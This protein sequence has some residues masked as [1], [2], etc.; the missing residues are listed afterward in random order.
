LVEQFVVVEP[1]KLFMELL[2]ADSEV[3][4]TG[5]LDKAGYLNSKDCWLPLGQTEGNWSIVGNQQSL[6][7]TALADKIVNS[8][9]AVLIAEC[10][11][12]GVNPDSPSAPKTMEE[13]VEKFF[14]IQGGKL[15][16]ATPDQRK[17]VSD[18]IFLVASGA[19]PEGEK[20]KNPC[21]TLLDL[22]EGQP[23]SRMTKTLLSLPTQGKPNK[24]KI[25]FVQGL[26]NMG[27]TGVLPFCGT[28]NY[29]LILSKRCPYA[30]A[31]SPDSTKWS[32][33]IIRRLR[34]SED[35]R[36]SVYQYLAPGGELLTIPDATLPILP[37]EYPN[38][39]SESM[40]YGTCIKLYEYG[41]KP[42]GLRG[43]AILDLNY[44][45]SR[46][47]YS[48]A[49]PIRICERRSGYAAH[50]KDATLAGMSVRLED[51]R[52]NVL[53]S[54]NLETGGQMH[55]SGLGDL[56]VK[57]YGFKRDIGRGEA[58]K[59]WMSDKGILFALNGQTH[60]FYRQDFFSR[61][62]VDLG[63]L[64]RDLMV[65]V[66]FTNVPLS[67]R[68][69]ILMPSR[70]RI[71]EGPDRDAI[72]S[73]LE[74]FLH[75]HEGLRAFNEKRR[76]EELEAVFGGDKPLEKVL[77]KLLKRSPSLANLFGLGKQLSKP[78]SFDWEKRM[79][80]YQGKIFPT[81]FR[82]ALEESPSKKV[83]ANSV[84][85]FH[86]ETDAVNDYFVRSKKPGI[87]VMAPMEVKKSFKLWNGIATLTLKP[88]AGSASGSK[89]SI[90]ATVSDP[91]RKEPFPETSLELIVDPPS[92]PLKGKAS[93]GGE[94]DGRNGR[95]KK[96]TDGDSTSKGLSLPKIEGLIKGTHATWPD[97][98]KSDNDGCDAV[99]HSNQLDIFVNMS[100]P[101]L[102]TE[103]E[104]SKP[105]EKFVLE[106]QFKY[107]L[108]LLSLA[109]YHDHI[110]MAK[111]KPELSVAQDA[112][113]TNV[114][115]LDEI[116]RATRS[117]SMIILPLANTLDAAAKS[118]S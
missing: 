99:P 9:D 6:S 7:A 100:N 54:E 27:G 65:I 26:F 63:Y 55:V 24:S 113:P 106:N 4:V 98:F 49:I 92:S 102:Q 91:Q 36:I 21:Y 110:E 17:A 10:L 94:Q 11:K 67:K 37:G 60:A 19:R 70:D 86:F 18:R 101:Y 22:G 50:S 90:T 44:E 31:E 96:L 73:A 71:R 12:H 32:F 28:Q 61:E 66:D 112:L 114:D 118:V 40:T 34:P 3:E 45:L 53:E 29:E 79:G 38:A 87:F 48:L 72:E 80:N 81:F 93:S 68:E 25:R 39:Y 104:T 58:R 5:I 76:Q 41:I 105:G 64:Q 103:I 109:M 52:S 107:G 46:Q 15:T 108:A 57:I 56:P 47:F 33:T 97:H 84:C 2:Q 111:Q 69:D 75:D 117:A 89:I 1:K 14:G 8:V 42:D 43:P 77:G 62:R 23:P 30:S 35:E 85:R 82:L 13:A 115:I 95:F 88:P 20:G 51:D 78:T 74:D 116:R 16:N 83:P 59:R